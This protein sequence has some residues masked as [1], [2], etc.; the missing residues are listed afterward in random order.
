M[1]LAIS[2]QHIFLLLFIFVVP[3]ILWIL[4]ILDIVKSD[5]KDNTIK[6]VWLLVVI[7]L[8]VIGSILYFIA[9][10]SSKNL[11]V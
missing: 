9:G 2:Y 7:F 10:R 5:F 4:A 6:I 8:P 11:S 3:V 1:L